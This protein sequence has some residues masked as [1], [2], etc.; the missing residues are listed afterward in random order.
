MSDVSPLS[1]ISELSFDSTLPSPLLI[2]GLLPL[3]VSV[4]SLLFLSSFFFSPSF[5]AHFPGFY[6]E[7]SSVFFAKEMVFL[8]WLLVSH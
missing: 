7:N 6:A 4:F 8:V 3:L 5:L 1:G 2:L